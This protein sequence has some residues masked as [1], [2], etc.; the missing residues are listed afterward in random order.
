MVR[1]SRR[2]EVAFH[3]V[4]RATYKMMVTVHD[5]SGEPIRVET[6]YEDGAPVKHLT[7]MSSNPS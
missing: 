6:T 7:L 3:E 1:D 4:T 2:D 5:K